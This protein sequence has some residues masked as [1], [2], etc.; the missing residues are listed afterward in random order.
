MTTQIPLPET[1]NGYPAAYVH[2]VLA[3]V[4]KQLAPEQIKVKSGRGD[5]A[6]RY[7][8]ARDV[9]ARL[10]AV[11]PADWSFDHEVISRPAP[12]PNWFELSPDEA[13]RVR[14][15]DAKKGLPRDKW[16]VKATLT[17]CGI[18]RS[19]NGTNESDDGFDPEKAAVSDALKRCAAKFGFAIELYESTSPDL[20]EEVRKGGAKTPPKRPASDAPTSEPR[21]IRS[22][23][24]LKAHAEKGGLVWAEVAEVLKGKG[25]LKW[26]DES[27]NAQLAVINELIRQRKEN[28]SQTGT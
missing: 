6:Q 8:D 22:A 3:E 12:L 10:N 25:Y 13:K 11:C 17:I 2:H 4:A 1:I 27:H 15:K 19:D 26:T 7:I 14:D 28:P 18:S 9:I 20:P 23:A 24:T 21:P 5:G 16:V